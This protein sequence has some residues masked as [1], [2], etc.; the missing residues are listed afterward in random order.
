VLEDD[1]GQR[2][3]HLLVRLEDLDLVGAVQDRLARHAWC[4]EQV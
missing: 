2:R 4:E 1:V 3:A